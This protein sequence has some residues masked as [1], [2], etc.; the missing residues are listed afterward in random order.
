VNGAESV[1]EDLV[2]FILRITHEIWEERQVERISEYYSKDVIVRSPSG[3][4]HG[5]EA[6][7]EA[8]HATL[9]EFPDRQLLGEDVLT[10][11]DDAVSFS[12]HRIFSTATHLG[13]GYFGAPTGAPLRYRVIADCAVRD[14]VIFDEWLVRDFGAI[15]RQLG[16]EPRDFAARTV[17]D[18]GGTTRESDLRFLAVPPAY[19]GRGNAHPAGAALARLVEA[20]VSDVPERADTGVDRAAQFDLPGGASIV[21]A[22][23]GVRAS[24]DMFAPF[25]MSDVSVDHVL[26][27]DDARR[28][29]R[30]AVRVTARGRH[31]RAG[32]F[33]EP[34]GREVSLLTIWHAEFSRHG[35]RRAFVLADE[36]AVWRQVLSGE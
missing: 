6:V 28:G 22:R 27:C 3:V 9:A 30:A 14:G 4:S 1:E 31:V 29:T 10:S 2:D 13:S 33:G 8:T 21:G 24:A 18:A 32:M 5:N 16:I 23:I 19:A 11:S 26:G 15:T 17:A 7:I 35:V 36:V 25:R 12:S 20:V 34:T